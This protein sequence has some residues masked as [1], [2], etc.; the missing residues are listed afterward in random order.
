L[1][2]ASLAPRNFRPSSKTA[3]KKP[4]QPGSTR[5]GKGSF[6]EEAI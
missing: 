6:K 2:D 3:C 1:I 4:I 5:L